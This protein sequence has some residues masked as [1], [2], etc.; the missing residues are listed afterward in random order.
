MLLGQKEEAINIY[1]WLIRNRDCDPK[2]YVELSL[3]HLYTG[4][5][6]A[7][8]N[9]ILSAY[10]RFSEDP[11]VEDTFNDI[12]DITNSLNDNLKNIYFKNLGHFVFL[13]NSYLRALKYIVT[14]MTI[15]GYFDF[16]I[17]RAIDLLALF[18]KHKI[19]FRDYKLAALLAEYIISE[20]TGEQMYI[21]KLLTGINGVSK[22]TIRRWDKRVRGIAQKEIDIILEKLLDEYTG[23]FK[24]LFNKNE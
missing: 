19:I 20:L 17:N 2:N 10:M 8:K 21:M 16:E 1:R 14:S 15:R 13:K 12:K 23:E 18:N 7:A 22:A 11:L 3:S 4:D 6:D 24:A 9:I 5:I